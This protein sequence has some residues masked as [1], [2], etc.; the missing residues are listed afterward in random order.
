MAHQY[1]ALCILDEVKTGFRVAFGGAAQHYGVTPDMST[2]GKAC[3]NGYPGSFVSGRKEIL[4][5]KRCQSTWMSATFH[6]DPLS[7]VALECVTKELKRRDGIVHQWKIGSRLIEGV[8]K[9]CEAGGLGYRL[10]GPGANPNP[11][12]PKEER[13]RCLHAPWLLGTW[14]LFA[15]HPPHVSHAFAL[16]A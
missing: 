1:G 7:M 8:N 13:D 10:R 16:R 12:L 4:S 11:R 5:D 6:C 15:S 9:T 3:S 2:F 14:V